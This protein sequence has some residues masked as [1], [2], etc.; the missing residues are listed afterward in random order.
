MHVVLPV[1]H[2]IGGV[3]QNQM[4]LHR[5]SFGLW[6]GVMLMRVILS[7]KYIYS[8]IWVIQCHSYG[9]KVISKVKNKMAARYFKVHND[10][11]TNEAR[12]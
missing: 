2:S 1:I 11:S 8:I 6:V 12:K 10:C 7:E 4:H 3:L 5:L 9:R